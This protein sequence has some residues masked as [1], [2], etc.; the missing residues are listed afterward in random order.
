MEI[1]RQGNLYSVRSKSELLTHKRR[2]G[3]RQKIKGFSKNSA[4]RLK[5]LLA[6]TIWRGALFVTLTAREDFSYGKVVAFLKRYSR[7]WGKV[8][9]I[10]KKEYQ[11]RGTVH[12][13]LLILTRSW[14]P[15][16]WIK[17]AWSQIIGDDVSVDV[18]YAS[19]RSKVAYY[20]SKYLAK[21]VNEAEAERERS[22]GIG[23]L[24]DSNISCHTGRF[25][26]VFN[27]ENLRFYK[28]V[29]AKITQDLLDVYVRI[30]NWFREN[31]MFYIRS[32]SFVYYPLDNWT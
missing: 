7:R 14:L 12:Y 1:Y 3:M 32:F 15:L 9:V 11:T 20:V 30:V 24:D 10:W 29:K 22:E 6:K 4:R 19:N 21:Q 27:R 8:P 17:N 25:W 23:V 31:D 2:P 13:H 18:R 16:M 26:G 5:R 28:L